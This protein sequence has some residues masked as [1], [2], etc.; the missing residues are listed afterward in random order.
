[1]NPDGPTCKH[2]FPTRPKSATPN[3]GHGDHR[4]HHVARAGRIDGLNVQRWSPVSI[5]TTTTTT[6]T[7]TTD[8]TTVR[9]NLST[10]TS[11]LKMAEGSDGNELSLVPYGSRENNE[12]FLSVD[13]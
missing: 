8:P 3:L 11:S 6:T 10:S 7:T 1:M 12:I 5:I 9:L 4:H 13:A 2:V